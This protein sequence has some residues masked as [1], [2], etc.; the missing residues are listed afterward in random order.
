MALMNNSDSRFAKDPIF[1]FV[2][3]MLKNK[4]TSLTSTSFGVRQLPNEEAL[5]VGQL[6]EILKDDSNRQAQLGKQI[7][8]FSGTI[9]G[10]TPYW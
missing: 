8:A 9:T 3:L 6:R 7:T 2:L 10:S 4:E 5:N 1:P